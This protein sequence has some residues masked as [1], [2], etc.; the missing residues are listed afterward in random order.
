[1]DQP[2]Q[3]SDEKIK[4]LTS[5]S[6]PASSMAGPNLEGVSQITKKDGRA[7]SV[8]D[9]RGEY[10][11]P[12]VWLKFYEAINTDKAKITFQVLIQTGCRINE[13]RHIRKQ[14]LDFERNTIR[15]SQT[16]TKAIKGEKKGKP[17]TIPVSSQFMKQL[18]KH[19]GNK[20]N[21]ELIGLLSTPAANIALKNKLKEIGV[22]NYYMY[23]VHNV[24]KTHGNW[25]KT[26]GNSGIMKVDASEICLRLGHDFE[27]FLRSYGSSGE[28]NHKDILQAKEILGDLYA[29]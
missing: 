3:Q 22:P 1:M 8:R 11:M 28:F 12:N 19:F 25:L 2:T 6:E 29:R 26:L 9:H 10:L 16:K 13:G 5:N 17:R 24:R 14:D 18:R 15:L 21:D 27:T 23:S 20:Q 7:Y 4:S